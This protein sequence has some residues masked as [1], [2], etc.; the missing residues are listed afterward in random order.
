M[1]YFLGVDIGGTKTHTVIANE[2][3]NVVGFGNSGP[4]NHQ[5]V[6]YEGML[7]VLKAGFSQALQAASL[8]PE[9]IAGAGVGIA[10]Y[11]WPS[12]KAKM[13]Q[14]VRR[15]GITCPAGL[16]NDCIP[17][18][19]AGAA[20]GWGVV[21]VSGTGCNCR[22]RDAS[23]QREGRVTGY[24]YQLGENAGSSELVWKAM[25]H[26]AFEWT[27]RGPATAL[28]PALVAFAGAKN[29]EDLIE[30][31]TEQR[32]EVGA[33][34]ARIVFDVAVQG[35]PVAREVIR[36]AGVELGQMASGVIRQLGFEKL[37]FDVV[38]SGGM[39]DGGAM[40]VDPMRETINALAPGARLVRLTVPPVLGAVMIGMEQAGLAVTP[41]IRSTL[42]DS[43]YSSIAAH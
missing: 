19:V 8:L 3:G 14:I 25:Q 22:G 6:G 42:A 21:V 31:Y 43:I 28:T 1:Q 23:R 40:L 7:A 32:Y 15:M 13:E 11:D 17:G 27:K 39:F 34:A 10:G 2:D 5:G 33:S 37:E 30:G 24:G 36:W 16:V 20:N 18:L 12:E 29:L 26:V 38:L 41:A 9:Q 4:G 35:D